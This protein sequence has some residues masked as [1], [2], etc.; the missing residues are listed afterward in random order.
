MI[1]VNIRFYEELNDFLP[2]CKQKKEYKLIASLGQSIKDLIESENIP[3]TEIDMIL[4][5]GEAVDFTYRVR[6]LDRISV[7]PVFETFDITAASPLRLQPL[8]NPLFILDVHLGKLARYLRIA[9]FDSLYSNSFEDSEISEI[10]AREGRIVLTRD[11]GLLKRSIVKRGYWIRSQSPAV[12]LKEVVKKF[13]LG[14]R[15][16]LFTICPSCN[17]ILEKIAKEKIEDRLP[18]KTALYYNDFSI[19]P[20]CRKIYWK[21]SHFRNIDLLLEKI[22]H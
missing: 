3:H 4:V 21:G 13:D 17:G 22:R 10:S 12:Q 8:R 18:E 1:S 7:F 9:G 6:D 5:N 11:R 16:K 14:S 19:C 2:P 20:S 15:I